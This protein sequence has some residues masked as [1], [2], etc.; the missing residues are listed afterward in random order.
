MVLADISDPLSVIGISANFH[1]GASLEEYIL[2]PGARKKIEEERLVS[3]VHT[4]AAQGNLET[5]VIL[6]SVA[7]PYITE[8]RE[9]LHLHA[10]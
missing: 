2:L 9:S 5:T 1:I 6:V 3:C 4:C 10:A 8:S 7:R